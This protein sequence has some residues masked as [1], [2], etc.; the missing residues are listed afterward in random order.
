MLQFGMTSC[1]RANNSRLEKIK[2]LINKYIYIYIY[3]HTLE[4]FKH[5]SIYN[6]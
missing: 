4:I 2:Y 3:I 1:N 5:F 6:V